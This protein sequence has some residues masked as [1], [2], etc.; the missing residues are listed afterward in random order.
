VRGYRPADLDALCASGDVVWMGAGGI[1][2][3]DGRIALGFR[4]TLRNSPHYRPCGQTH[5]APSLDLRLW[6]PWWLPFLDR[7]RWHRCCRS[8][9]SLPSGRNPLRLSEDYGVRA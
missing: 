2:A 6:L 9:A 8:D 1:G 7:D 5:P 4:E 3:D